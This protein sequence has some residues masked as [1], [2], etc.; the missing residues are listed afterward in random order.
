M[1]RDAMLKKLEAFLERMGWFDGLLLNW[2][3]RRL[4]NFKAAEWANFEK[5]VGKIVEGR[6]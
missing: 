2:R 4:Q 1:D 3:I 5:Q 6:R